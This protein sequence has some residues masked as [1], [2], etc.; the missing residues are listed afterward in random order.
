MQP[1]LIFKANYI[2]A[3]L[4]KL[5]SYTK[6]SIWKNIP[7]LKIVVG[8][9]VVIL[10]IA[11]FLFTRSK[12]FQGQQATIFMTV[13][14]V[15]GIIFYGIS[16]L[17]RHRKHIEE[18]EALVQQTKDKGVPELILT[19]GTITA[20]FPTGTE[21]LY[22]EEIG[23]AGLGKD[24][25]HLTSS[26]TSDKDYYWLIPRGDVAADSWKALGDYIIKRTSRATLI[27]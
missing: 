3:D 18:V 19:G 27:D 13:I 26:R 1:P 14:L 21:V 11:G 8:L 5:Y 23:R 9:L 4:D 17:V 25:I 15:G 10:P 2:E 7:S 6:E 20:K 22:W 12:T 24:V 16:L